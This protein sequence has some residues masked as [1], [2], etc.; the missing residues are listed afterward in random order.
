MKQRLQG[1][2]HIYR[3]REMATWSEYAYNDCIALGT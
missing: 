3:N 2:A 1:D